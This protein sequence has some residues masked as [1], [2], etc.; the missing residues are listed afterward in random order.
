MEIYGYK[1]F[2]KDMT[3]RHGKTFEEG[4]IYIVDGPLKWGKNGNGYHFCTELEDTLRFVNGFDNDIQIASIISTDEVLKIDDYVYEYF[5]MYVSRSIYIDH[6][7]T[8]E[9][10]INH[11]LKNQYNFYGVIRFIAGFRLTSEEIQLFKDR[12]SRYQDVLL[13]LNYYQGSDTEDR[14]LILRPWMNY[15]FCNNLIL[16]GWVF[17][18]ISLGHF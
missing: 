6:I 9:E 17:W 1:A 8:R 11:M 16:R 5:D 10:I 15:F 18:I 4:K 2:A 13:A 14:K 7:L 3:N 12:F